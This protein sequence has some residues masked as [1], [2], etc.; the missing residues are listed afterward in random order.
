MEDRNHRRKVLLVGRR[1][2]GVSGHA[3]DMPSSSRKK[4]IFVFL[5][6]LNRCSFSLQLKVAVRKPPGQHREI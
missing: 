4:E 3:L 6:W 1:E 5:F 2:G